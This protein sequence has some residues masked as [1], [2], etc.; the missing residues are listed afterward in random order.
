MR[1]EALEMSRIFTRKSGTDARTRK[2]GI[3]RHEPQLDPPKALALAMADAL[4][5]IL[6]SER[7]VA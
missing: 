6:D 4:E 1:E 2:R 3:V 5:A 7:R